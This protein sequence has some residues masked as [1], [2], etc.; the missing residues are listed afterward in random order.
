MEVTINGV[1]HALPD[2][3]TVADVVSAL[4]AGERGCAV[5]LDGV[6]VPRGEWTSRTVRPDSRVEVVHAVQ[7]G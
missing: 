4:D 5:A 3:A 6:V 7:G 1:P 2:D